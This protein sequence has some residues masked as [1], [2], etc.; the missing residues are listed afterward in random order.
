MAV[1]PWTGMQ[2]QLPSSHHRPTAEVE[3]FSALAA[4]MVG[5]ARQDGAAAQVQS[6]ALGYIRDQAAAHFGRD[7]KRLDCLA[8]PA[9]PRHR[10]RR[11]HPVASRWPG[12]APTVVGAD[13][14]RGQHRGGARACRAKRACDRL[15]RVDRGGAGRAG[16]AV[17]RGAGDG[18][19]RARRRRRRCS[20]QRCAE[21]VKPGGL[22]IAATLNRT[23]KSFALAIV[24][25]EYMLRWLPR[26]HPSLGQ[27]RHA[28]RTGDRD[29][30]GRACV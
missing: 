19:G 16:R 30:A 15:P 26:R 12:S 6:G 11:R 3:Q 29:G 25:A 27:V 22:M 21:M 14:A 10:L 17:R 5:P 24:G 2:R 28:G 1:R 9:H 20:L 18:G 4:A 13:P 8:G 7:P 23:L